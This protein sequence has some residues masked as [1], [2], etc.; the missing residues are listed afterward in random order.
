[1]EKLLDWAIALDSIAEEMEAE[2]DP[3]IK[4][5]ASTVRDAEFECNE[6]KDAEGA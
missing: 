2:S 5:I 4:A 3:R 1:M 6:I